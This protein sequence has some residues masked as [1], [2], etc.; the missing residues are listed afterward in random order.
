MQPSDTTPLDV[1]TYIGQFPKPV[2]DYL[3]SIRSI[4]K[5]AA[6]EAEEFISYKMPAYKLNGPLV[7]FA[8]FKSHIGFF[9]IPTNNSDFDKELAAYKTGRGSV[10][11]PLNK[12]LPVDL[13]T[14]IVKFRVQE[15][16]A[17]AKK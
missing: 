7:Y 16:L 5:K 8:A 3:Q 2:Q 15:N 9:D 6:P 1:D 11:F 14:K 10:Q 13:I 17:K 12:S 4:I